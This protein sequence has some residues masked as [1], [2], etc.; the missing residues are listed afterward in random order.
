MTVIESLFELTLTT[1]S[2]RKTMMDL[3]SAPLAAFWTKKKHLLIAKVM[4][5]L[6][7]AV[8]YHQYLPSPYHRPHDSGNPSMV[9]QSS[10]SARMAISGPT[11]KTSHH[12]I[13][14]RER[15]LLNTIRSEETNLRWTMMSPSTISCTDISEHDTFFCHW[16]RRAFFS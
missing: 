6:N 14:T 12:A 5:Q 3:K 4:R 9:K 15:G 16:L 2:W 1:Y 11:T 7:Q 10:L 13:R 8:T